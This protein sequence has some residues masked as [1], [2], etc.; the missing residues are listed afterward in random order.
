MLFGSFVV[1]S[2]FYWLDLHNGACVAL[3]NPQ[4]ESTKLW[5]IESDL[6]NLIMVSG[7]E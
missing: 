3:A 1:L 4:E 7:G 6:P 2:N 5:L